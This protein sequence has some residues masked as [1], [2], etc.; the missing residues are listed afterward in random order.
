MANWRALFGAP[1]T[2]PAESKSKHSWPI[3]ELFLV[4]QVLQP[5]HGN[6]VCIY[7]MFESE[8]LLL[9]FQV[10]HGLDMT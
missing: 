1:G 7:S 6:N 4:H 9:G 5:L 2:C 10:I 3:G 8:R